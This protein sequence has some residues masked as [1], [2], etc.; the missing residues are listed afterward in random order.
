MKRLQQLIVLVIVFNIGV[1]KAQDSL[2]FY[3]SGN[4]VYSELTSQID[5]AKFSTHDYSSPDSISIMESGIVKYKKAISEIDSITF[6]NTLINRKSIVDKMADDKNYSIFYQGLVATGVVNSL[7]TDRDKS[8]IYDQY[9]SLVAIPYQEGSGSIDELP[10]LRRYGFTVLMESD[11]T[12]NSYNIHT[13]EDLKTY[14]AAH[15]Y[16]ENPSDASVTDITDPRNSLNKFIAYHIINKKLSIPMFIDAYDTDNMIKTVDMYE[17]L[18]PMCPNTLIEIKKERSTGVTNLINQSPDTGEAVHIIKKFDDNDIY[19]GFYYGI[20]KI[21]SFDLNTASNLSSKRLRFDMTAVFPEMTNN[22]MRGSG[23]VQSWAIPTGYLKRLTYSDTTHVSYSNAY[24]G[25]LDYQGDEISFRGAYDF[26][27]VTPTIP[28]GTYEVRFGY[29]P[30]SSRGAAQILVDGMPVSAPIDYRILA[31]D[32]EIGYVT[33]GTDPTDIDGYEND[34]MMRNHGY[35]KGPA[36]YKDALNIWY[37]G[38]VARNNSNSLRKILGTYS[39][40]SAGNH[41]ITVKGLIS[42]QFQID[43][44]EFVPVNVLESEDIY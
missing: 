6:E 11:S 35:M 43:F 25:Y 21:L 15:V 19:N 16:N 23:K 29:L 26:L 9:K 18:E 12:Y 30:N 13:I 2:F 24:G 28:A 40:H 14:A 42:G 22:N 31:S 3:K 20:D 17:Y 7:K 5:S 32:P 44:I 41:E 27:F 33:P 8:Y 1:I 37:G 4:I 34:K 38:K 36:S 10:L 39:F